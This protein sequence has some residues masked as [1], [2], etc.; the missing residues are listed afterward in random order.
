LDMICS[1]K[2]HTTL[3][4]SVDGTGRQYDYFESEDSELD[5]EAKDQ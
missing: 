1:G 5:S 4:A 2:A 3:R